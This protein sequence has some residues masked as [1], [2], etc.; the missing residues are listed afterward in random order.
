MKNYLL[1]NQQMRQQGQQ[2]Q[3]SRSM[4]NQFDRTS[5][6]QN[7]AGPSAQAHQYTTNPSG[8][9]T[10]GSG[11]GGQSQGHR[12]YL[13]EAVGQ[14]K[15]QLNQEKQQV[16]YLAAAGDHL[17]NQNDLMQS[18][19]MA[20]V[21]G[22]QAYQQG[23]AGQVNLAGAYRRNALSNYAGSTP[24]GAQLIQRANALSNAPIGV[25]PAGIAMAGQN[26]AQLN[27]SQQR[28]AD[29]AT[30]QNALQ[31][32]FANGED[33][34]HRRDGGQARMA[35]GG[36]PVL[37]RKDGSQ[38]L[39]SE[40]SPANYD[41]LGEN[42]RNA[43]QKRLEDPNIQRRGLTALQKTGRMNSAA[44]QALAGMN[45]E[46][47]D[48]LRDDGEIDK[49]KLANV[50]KRAPQPKN[51]L[52]PG[53]GGDAFTLPD[54]QKTTAAKKKAAEDNQKMLAAG[55]ATDATDSDVLRSVG[56]EPE[57]IDSLTYDDFA[58]AMLNERYMDS[59]VSM[60][61][62][63]GYRV[64]R[65]M[66]RQLRN[67]FNTHGNQFHRGM[68]S[69]NSLQLLH[70]LQE[71]DLDNQDGVRDWFHN[72]VASVYGPDQQKRQENRYG[73]ATDYLQ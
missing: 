2:Q 4:G 46:P 65:S 59:I 31:Q 71:L 52:A 15:Y 11:G 63:D 24:G 29:V 5:A 35:P 8:S 22:S 72:W 40:S 12:N 32:G 21:N 28:A 55:N 39:T 53:D 69:D 10:A 57:N 54:G 13:A 44:E 70:G 16:N 3:V 61:P 14:Q 1:T 34:Y 17:T 45:V 36:F 9:Q 62:P 64:A 27:A 6:N 20:A 25:S 7:Q 51:Y 38:A 43:R 41:R 49:K 23:L 33:L 47:K 26:V 56:I 66:A 68:M 67:A 37:Q 58:N 18:Q 60:N 48:Y 42:N 50:I 19:Q 30:N 73:D